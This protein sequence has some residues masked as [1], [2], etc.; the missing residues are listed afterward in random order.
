MMHKIIKERDLL[1][2]RLSSLNTDTEVIYSNLAEEFPKVLTETENSISNAVSRI[3]LYKNR[4][5]EAEGT[6]PRTATASDNIQSLIEMI[7][8]EFREIHLEDDRLLASLNN[9][10][11][12]IKDLTEGIDIVRKAS[13]EIE[14][15]SLN[16]MTYAVKAGKAGGAFSYITEELKKV[17]S[18]TIEETDSLTSRGTHARE[19]FSNYLIYLRELQAVQK[20][21]IYDFTERLNSSRNELRKGI[22]D[23]FS[24]IDN[25]LKIGSKIKQ[26]LM[27]IMEEIQQQDII[28]QS[29]DHVLLTLNSIE[30]RDLSDLTNALDE[31]TYLIHITE[32]SISLLSDI[33]NKIETSLKIFRD[34]TRQVEDILKETDRQRELF[35]QR[36]ENNNEGLLSIMFCNSKENLNSL[37]QDLTFSVHKKE[38]ISSQSSNLFEEVERISEGFEDIESLVSK[39]NNISIA[40]KIEIAKQEILS[41]MNTTVEE[42]DALILNIET[43]IQQSREITN[44]F[45]K[46]T[47]DVLSTYFISTEKEFGFI[48]KYK[49]AVNASCSLFFGEIKALEKNLH[50]FKVFSDSFYQ[51]YSN[52]SQHLWKLENLNSNIR[53]IINKYKR[54]SRNA[55]IQKSNLMEINKISNWEIKNNRLQSIIKDF[56][57][58]HHKKQAAEIEGFEVEDGSIEGEITFF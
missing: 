15:I 45:H 41:N 1:V 54:I 4:N 30:D 19:L 33:Q 38:R 40:S 56:T 42:M 43:N 55:N 21:T 57:I 28:R 39:F 51:I 13:E 7:N 2:E 16:A 6:E 22:N 48:D 37:F 32:L 9:S 25:L 31:Y 50:G 17:S 11:S 58:F 14:I 10:L 46:T 27:L 44:T 49:R 34:S 36:L 47:R 52:T 26:P 12:H 3:S 8:N 53:Q 24:S 18:K 5:M 20:K 35:A 23:L 29:I